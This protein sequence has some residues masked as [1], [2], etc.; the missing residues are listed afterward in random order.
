MYK[1]KDSCAFI[2]LTQGRPVEIRE[3][4]LAFLIQAGLKEAW[5]V[6]WPGWTKEDGGLSGLSDYIEGLRIEIAV[7][8]RRVKAARRI[9][10]ALFPENEK[11]QDEFWPMIHDTDDLLDKQQAPVV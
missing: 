8:K 10:R 3:D 1:D 5:D 7:A 2:S 6:E 11:W 4:D 9:L